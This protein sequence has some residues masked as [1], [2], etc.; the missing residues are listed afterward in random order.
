MSRATKMAASSALMIVCSSSCPEA[1]MYMVLLAG[2]CITA[3]PSRGRPFL[4]DP[5]V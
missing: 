1:F 5:S 3:A 4:S 2:E